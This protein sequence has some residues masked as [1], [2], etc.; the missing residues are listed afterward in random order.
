M[1]RSSL[2]TVGSIWLVADYEKIKRIGEGTFGIVCKL[3]QRA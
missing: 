1:Y 3:R 2:V